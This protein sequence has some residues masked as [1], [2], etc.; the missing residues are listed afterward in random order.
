MQRA[1]NRVFL[2]ILLCFVLVFHGC[3]GVVQNSV[4][5]GSGGAVQES[6]QVP[7]AADDSFAA[8]KS[9]PSPID[10]P[11]P[12]L[13]E[14][15]GQN[16]IVGFEGKE[17]TDEIRFY[18]HQIKPAGIVIYRRNIEDSAQITDLL[19]ELQ[20]IAIETTGTRYFVMIDEEPDG[21]SRMGLLKNC[22]PLGSPYWKKIDQDVAILSS[23]GFN[24]EL[25]PV[26]DFPFNPQSF[27]RGRVPV[28]TTEELMSFNQGFIDILHAH[29]MFATLK[30][31]PGMGAFSTDPHLAI[32]DQEISKETFQQ[33]LDLFQHGIDAGADFIMTAHA[34]YGHVDPTYPATLSRLI[35]TD[36]LKEKMQFQGLI[37][38]DDLSDMALSCNLWTLDELGEL[39]ILAGRHLILYS[40]KLSRTAEVF[41]YIL[42]KCSQDELLFKQVQQNYTDVSAFKRSHQMDSSSE[43]KEGL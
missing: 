23:F 37:V 10:L 13:E 4:I 15:L 7:A 17:I 24:T 28:N 14:M 5:K 22:C 41:Q 12:P 40:H 32:P 2:G 1:K 20:E 39:S 18:L 27:M 36:I 35:I 3:T 42:Q 26:V 43:M 6:A 25:A 19:Q 33:S 38:T 21:A 8:Q 31:F 29:G 16:F 34:V 9:T 11:L 30:H